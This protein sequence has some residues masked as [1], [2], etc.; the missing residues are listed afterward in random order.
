MPDADGWCSWCSSKP[1]LLALA[2]AAL[3]TLFTWWA[4]PFV[5]S[6]INPPD[7]PVRLSLP[8][9]WR[10]FGFSVTLT[11]IVTML[12]G[13]SPAL[14]ASAVSQASALK[15]GA[16]ARSRRRVMH[17]VIAAQTA[18]C[19]LVLFAGGLFVASFER[20][21]RRPLGFDAERLLVLDAVPASPQSSVV[22]EEV[23]DHLRSIAGVETVA[24]AGWPLLSR[25][26]WNGFVSIDG[27]PPGPILAYFLSVSPGW[28]AT[29]K[30]PL[31]DGRDFQP[32]RDVARRRDRQPDVRPKQYFGAKAP[33]RTDVRQGARIV[34]ASSA[35]PG[36]CDT[37]ACAEPILPVAYVPFRGSWRRARCNRDVR[38]VHRPHG[39]PASGAWRRLLRQRGAARAE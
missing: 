5:V 33:D 22:W 37:A 30:I 7:N 34:T 8:I 26:A 11:V 17:V 16:D 21:S 32:T 4:T 9:D 39:R 23:A 35:S 28:L 6:H 18:F 3:G 27:A 25:T 36:T 19:F 38:R 31:I 13:L 20:L 10:V 24:L 14:R 1:R 12:F 15:S 29:M 2:A